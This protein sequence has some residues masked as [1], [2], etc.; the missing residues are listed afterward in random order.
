MTAM[1]GSNR[2]SR[3][4][5]SAAWMKSSERLAT[6]QCSLERYFARRTVLGSGF[7]IGRGAMI[8]GLEAEAEADTLRRC[9]VIGRA[10]SPT[11]KASR[12]PILTRLE[13]PQL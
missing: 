1:L 3:P 13:R 12:V 7:A 6:G 11:T 4:L 5:S 2:Q 10:Q 8:V 9:T